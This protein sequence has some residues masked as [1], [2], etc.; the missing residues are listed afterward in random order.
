MN[1]RTLQQIHKEKYI[2]D[3]LL[4]K[5]KHNEHIYLTEHLAVI[6]NKYR[7]LT[8]SNPFFKTGGYIFISSNTM[9]SFGINL[10]KN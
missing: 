9:V 7:Q 4:F 2:F 1:S 6:T 10:F 5:F 3:L 8:Q